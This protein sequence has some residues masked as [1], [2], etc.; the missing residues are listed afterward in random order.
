MIF[1][2]IKRVFNEFLKKDII[3]EWILSIGGVGRRVVKYKYNFDFCYFIGVS[4]DEE[5]IR[6]IV[7]NIIG[8]IL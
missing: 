1:L 6:F 3:K 2:I 4:I 5:K 8:K 7:I